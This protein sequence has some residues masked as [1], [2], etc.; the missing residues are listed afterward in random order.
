MSFPTPPGQRLAYDLDG[1]LGF[2]SR[3]NGDDRNPVQLPQAAL[4]G[5]N[6]DQ[7][8]LVI[9]GVGTT[10]D[11]SERIWNMQAAADQYVS[12]NWLTLFFPHPTHIQGFLAAA[13]GAWFFDGSTDVFSELHADISIQ[14]SADT[15]N[16]AD[17]TWT[18]IAS[19]P[20]ADPM[21]PVNLQTAATGDYGPRLP[22]GA[23][24]FAISGST[25]SRTLATENWTRED[26][27]VSGFGWRAVAGTGT[28][29]V[30]A[31]RILLPSVPP[32]PG[33][34][35]VFQSMLLLLHL[36]GEPDTTATL[37]RVEYVQELADAPM[38]FNWGDVDMLSEGETKAFRVKNLSSTLTAE[39]VT[40]TIYDAVPLGVPES[41]A[42]LTL[43]KDGVS[44]NASVDITSIGPGLVSEVVYVRLVPGGTFVGSRSPR[45]LT[46]VGGWS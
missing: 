38:D 32:G 11:V 41:S 25:R 6:A 29:N 7:G 17:G 12:K 24:S 31:L 5:L 1:T 13:H 16:G 28:R 37:D 36:Y 20:A 40:V 45:L 9:P 22:S 15:T 34:N 30:A 8:G 26:E 18:E 27:G 4:S 46:E 21:I 33:G 2:I 42:L 19:V 39:N 23:E 44:W 3:T 43:S 14:T 35:S 10:Y